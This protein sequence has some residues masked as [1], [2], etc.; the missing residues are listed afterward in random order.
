MNINEATSL[1]NCVVLCTEGEPLSRGIFESQ[2]LKIPVIASDS[3]GN[4]ELI[5]DCKTGLL[6]EL[7]N[8]AS[9]S[10]K[11]NELLDS[12]QLRSDIISNAY[13]FVVETFDPAKT[14]RQEEQVYKGIL[15]IS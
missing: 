4:L 5:E 3:G 14:V 10:S 12:P 13:N 6:Y 9:L 15:G 1:L 2:F 11:M 8:P 7:N